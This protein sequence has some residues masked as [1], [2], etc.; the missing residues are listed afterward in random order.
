VIGVVKRWSESIEIGCN[1]RGARMPEGSDDID[2][3]AGA[4]KEDC[5]H[6]RRG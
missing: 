5:R 2:T 4:R 6:D 1:R 3:L